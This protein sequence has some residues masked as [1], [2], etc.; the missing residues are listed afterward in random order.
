MTTGLK[1]HKVLINPSL[2]FF[3]I[4]GISY[5]FV[6]NT[7]AVVSRGNYVWLLLCKEKYG[8]SRT[9]VQRITY[10]I[11]MVMNNAV[12]RDRQ[13]A[14]WPIAPSLAMDAFIPYIPHLSAPPGLPSQLIFYPFVSLNQHNGRSYRRAML[15][16]CMQFPCAEIVRF[17]AK[18]DCYAR[19]RH[20]R[21]FLRVSTSCYSLS[22]TKHNMLDAT[23]CCMHR[24]STIFSLLR[25]LSEIT[26]RNRKK[27]NLASYK[28][29]KLV[30]WNFNTQTENDQL[31]DACLRED[32]WW[33]FL[34]EKVGWR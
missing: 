25:T 16:S 4:C 5:R 30:F 15:S 27:R 12:W 14:N 22:A 32:Y 11:I 1:Y 18:Q 28:I 17:L 34:R 24:F 19:Q 2:W 23:G 10:V 20:W 9:H 13:P 33:R 6:F 7:T 29:A 31:P 3:Q 26:V 8:S 21:R